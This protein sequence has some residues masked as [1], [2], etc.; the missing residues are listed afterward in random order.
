MVR[1]PID[2]V[3]LSGI[4]ACMSL[5][6]WCLATGNVTGSKTPMNWSLLALRYACLLSITLAAAFMARGEPRRRG[7]VKVFVNFYP[8]L[9]VPMVYDSLGPLIELVN[10]YDQDHL[11]RCI[12]V[13][14]FGTDPAVVLTRLI[15]PV[16]TDVLYLAYCTYYVFPL[17]VGLALWRRDTVTAKRFIFTTAVAFYVSYV[18]YF[19]VP[20][21]GPRFDPAY[22]MAPDLR[23]SSLSIAIAD[24]LVKMSGNLHD[25][26][27]SGHTMITV[28]CL[29]TAYR[30]AR[31]VFWPLLPVGTLLV[32]A[33][34]YCRFHY[35]ID[36]IA[37]LALA[38]VVPPVT[39]WVF[40]RFTP[41]ENVRPAVAGAGA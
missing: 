18:G 3:N 15:H 14:I 33:T 34:M 35:V 10:P 36:V 31:R 20:A 12:D 37:G 13:L 38:A 30:H 24:G 26:F 5:A 29:M 28:I 25:V 41:A 1:R 16:L 7:L 39:R 23:T 8:M 6:G 27:P 22:D 4:L 9:V 19:L 2:L 17:T 32:C 21:L 40:D 11:L